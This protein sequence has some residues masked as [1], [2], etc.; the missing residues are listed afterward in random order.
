MQIGP[1]LEFPK[2]ETAPVWKPLNVCGEFVRA[3]WEATNINAGQAESSDCGGE[4]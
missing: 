3:L 2:Q 4:W 1:A